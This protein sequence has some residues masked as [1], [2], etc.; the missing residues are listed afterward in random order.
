MNQQTFTDW[1]GGYDPQSR[2]SQPV[3][4]PAPM[5]RDAKDRQLAAFGSTPDT[6]HPD[7][8]LGYYVQQP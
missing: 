1:A 5:F 8:Y 2:E 6:L 3:L 4:G 7:G